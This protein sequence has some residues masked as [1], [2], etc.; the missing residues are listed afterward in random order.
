MYNSQELRCN[1][2][3]YFSSRTIQGQCWKAMYRFF[4]DWTQ[5][6][7]KQQFSVSRWGSSSYLD[8]LAASY[9]GITLT[10]ASTADTGRRK[11]FLGRAGQGKE[12]DGKLFIIS[13]EREPNISKHVFSFY[14]GVFLSDFI[15][16]KYFWSTRVTKDSIT[17]C[18]CIMYGGFSLYGGPFRRVPLYHASAWLFLSL[19][20]CLSVCLS[21]SQSIYLSICFS[22]CLAVSQ[23]LCRRLSLY[24]CLSVCRSVCLNMM[25]MSAC[26][27]VSMSF[28]LT[29]MRLSTY[30]SVCMSVCRSASLVSVYPSVYWMFLSLFLPHAIYQSDPIPASM[31]L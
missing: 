26:L 25:R 23:S 16:G 10:K 28:C 2:L 7:K 12:V 13:G 18:L 4:T 30:L 9:S 20:S 11:F 17:S 22:V 8:A 31:C 15:I 6:N 1:H 21:A 19:S 5:C 24:V 27:S 3:T 14:V 29:I